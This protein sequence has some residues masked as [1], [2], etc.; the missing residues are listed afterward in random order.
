MRSPE[1]Q[2]LHDRIRVFAARHG[3]SERD[4][5]VMGA[6]RRTMRRILTAGA[7]P[8][9]WARAQNRF[10]QMSGEYS[11]G[12]EALRNLGEALQELDNRGGIDSS[13]PVQVRS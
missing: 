4:L 10:T 3:I 5:D 9:A 2:S 12:A 8:A 7:I 1:L 11:K 6:H 13:A